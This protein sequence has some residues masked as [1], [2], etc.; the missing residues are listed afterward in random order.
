ME[1]IES[2]YDKIM[3]ERLRE[4]QKLQFKP[5]KEVKET[6]AWMLKIANMYQVPN[7]DVI[8]KRAAFFALLGLW[9]VLK[10]HGD[11]GPA[12]QVR[13]PSIIFQF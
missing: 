4:Y 7:S 10:P 5:K 12:F 8:A 2:A 13:F 11:G 3:M 6:P 1:S 9:S